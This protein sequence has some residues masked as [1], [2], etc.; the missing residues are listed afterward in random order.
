MNSVL[1]VD[2]NQIELD[3]FKLAFEQRGL[4][5]ITTTNP[6]EAVSLAIGFKPDFIILDLYMGDQCGFD[7]CR[8]LKLER[9]TRNIP[10]MFVTGSRS[11]DDAIESLHLGCIDYI[12][13]PVDI[14][15]LVEIVLRHKIITTIKEAYSPI[16]KCLE[17]FAE[18]YNDEGER[19]N[20]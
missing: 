8:D 12:H 15:T 3:A 14:D 10:V 6:S 20:E 5:A 4:K 9:R 13:K 19:T 2:D 1:I 16:R 18:K 11:V 17:R 7:V